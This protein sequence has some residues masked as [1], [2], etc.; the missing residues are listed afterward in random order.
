M[1]DD[2]KPTT[3]LA[4]VR[5]M[6]ASDLDR[7]GKGQLVYV[8]RDGEVKDP[9][10]VRNRQVA[11]YA[12]FGGITAAGVALAATSFPVLIPFYLALGGRFMGTVRAVRRVNEASVA[13]SNGDSATGRALA[14]P[15][16]RAWWVPGRVRALA[17]LRVA[18]ADALDGRG[19]QALERVRRA[20]SRLSARLIQHQFSYYTE[21]N[22]LVAL[23][24]LK[25]ARLVLEARG[26][27]PAGEVLRLSHWI[28][29]MH[30]GVGEGVLKIDEHELHERMR[31][32]L[33]MTAGR[34]LLL[35]CAWAYA[36]RGE[37]DDA[38]FA[39]RQA[40]QREGSQRLEV[41][42][43][44]L[45]EWM[46]TYRKDHPAVDEPEAEEDM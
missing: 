1:A 30:L 17:E 6:I 19:E 46:T 22:L 33:S 5:P 37:H 14:E 12:L 13:L 34:D 7:A 20:R 8:G 32:G 24:K 42:M 15:V 3:E 45:A 43:P 31:K 18:I 38:I 44:K 21:I 40:M 23:G 39:W 10:S 25:E 29:E 28:A 2:A 35:L 4:L 11:A 41:S 36:A 9:S 16:A 26:N 27:V